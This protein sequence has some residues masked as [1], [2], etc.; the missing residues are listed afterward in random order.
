MEKKFLRSTSGQRFFHQSVFITFVITL[1]A[2]VRTR[3]GKTSGATRINTR[4]C[5]KRRE[6]VDCVCRVI[7][8]V[9]LTRSL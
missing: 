8:R 1:P 3:F 2:I 5:R 7:K 4:R 6:R 9:A